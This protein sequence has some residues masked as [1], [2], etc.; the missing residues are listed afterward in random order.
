LPVGQHLVTVPAQRPA[1]RREAPYPSRVHR[2]T[3]VAGVVAALV[4]LGAC[5][6]GGDKGGGGGAGST[7]TSTTAVART[8]TAI[9]EH[10]LP[11]GDGRTSKAPEVGSVFA[12]STPAGGG[13]AFQDGP[14]I[15]AAAGTWDRTTKLAVQGEVRWPGTFEEVVR[16][17]DNVLTGNGLPTTP[18][19][20]FPVAA[21]DPAY[22]YD[23]NPNTIRS[24]TLQVQVPAEPEVA[25]EPTCVGP[26]IGISR[27]GVP[28]F[29]AFDAKGDDAVAHEV[30]DRCDG[31]P[32]RTGQYH[33]HSSS[34]CFEPDESGLF[35][36]AL[37]GFGIY[38]VDPAPA[39]ADL[40]E[41]HGRTGEVLWHGERVTMYHYVATLDFPYLIGCY[42]GTPVRTS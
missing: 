16:G 7:T 24:T 39:S 15:D 31:H 26:T 28:I 29:S 11:L 12:C 32:E 20:T 30:Q 6:G 42:R 27:L 22:Q 2:T 13:G 19:G 34:R 38:V 4:V 23:R 33:F 25:D 18:T 21:A 5:G 36:Y 37:D 9:D 41:C 35:G 8:T 3:V 17:D 1:A 14:W 10:A 40:D